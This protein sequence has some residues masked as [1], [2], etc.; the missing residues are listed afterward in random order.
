MS[1]RS[2]PSVPCVPLNLNA[3]MT[4]QGVLAERI[5]VRNT[6]IAVTLF[7]GN[8]LNPRYYQSRE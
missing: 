6:G 5:F 7:A 1:I 4:V 3:I 8:F 2:Y